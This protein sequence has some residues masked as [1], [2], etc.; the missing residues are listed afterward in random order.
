MKYILIISLVFLFSCSSNKKISQEFNNLPQWVKNR[1]IDNFNYIGIAGVNKSRYDNNYHE[2]AR[3]KALEN[4]ASEISTSI[5][6]S[7]VYNKAE[8]NNI[9]SSYYRANIKAKSKNYLEG[10]QMVN[11]YNTETK[12]WVYYKLSKQ[13]YWDNFNKR[14]LEAIQNAKSKY[15][16]AKEFLNQYNIYQSLI[17][18][19]KAYDC[20]SDYLNQKLITT[21]EGTKK[22]LGLEIYNSLIDIIQNIKVVI[23]NNSLSINDLQKQLNFTVSYNNK[24]ISDLPFFINS[25]ECVIY[26]N[27]QIVN[28]GNLNFEI[29]KF[30]KNK[31]SELFFVNINL[32]KILN[33]A[34]TN[35]LIRKIIKSNK[36]VYNFKLAIQK[37]TFNI[38]CKNTDLRDK[39][40]SYFTK[41][42]IKLKENSDYTISLNFNFQKP[43]SKNNKTLIKG[44]VVYKLVQSEEIILSKNVEIRGIGKNN[45]EALSDINNQLINSVSYKIFREIYNKIFN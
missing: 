11:S 29:N 5:S 40:S 25:E 38:I 45:K 3:T 43:F 21:I 28:N 42:H 17:F 34:T 7:T 15:K 37:P 31:N 32:D 19:I 24:N 39:L 2:K 22:D 9:I 12:Y 6:A 26:E 44:Y 16:Q 23:K 41:Q 33:V 30:L 10:Y 27:K 36:K 18:H 8:L 13:R 20:L 1:P 4:I 35:F 14:K